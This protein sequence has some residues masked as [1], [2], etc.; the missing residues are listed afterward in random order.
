[1][2][3]YNRTDMVK[4]KPKENPPGKWDSFDVGIFNWMP[5]EYLMGYDPDCSSYGFH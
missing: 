5:I 2:S 3:E 4:Q 1:M